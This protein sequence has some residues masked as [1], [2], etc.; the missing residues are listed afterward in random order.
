MLLCG[1]VGVGVGVG[2][3]IVWALPWREWNEVWCV[4]GGFF[5]KV[6]LLDV[7]Y[8]GWVGGDAIGGWVSDGF[9]FGL[10]FGVGL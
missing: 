8:L 2:V 1:Y 4:A 3:W 10:V 6:S 5:L 9:E 7:D